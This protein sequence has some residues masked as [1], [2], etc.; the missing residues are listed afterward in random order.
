MGNADKNEMLLVLDD[1]GNS[2]DKVLN[3][4]YIHENGIFHNEVACVVVNSK[5]EILLQKRSKNKKSYPGCWALCAGHVVGYESIKHAILTEMNEELVMEIKEKN[6]FQLI[7]RMKN[8]RDDNRCFA[9][10]FCA[11]INKNAEE[12]LIQKE[13]VEE[14]KWFSLKEF[15]GMIAKEEGT[16]FKNNDYYKAI[17]EAL[18]KIFYTAGM[19]KIYATYI[20]QIEE[21][22]EA[23]KPTGRAVTREFAH[24]FGIWH[25]AASLIIINRDNRI[26]LQKR[27][28][29]KIRNAGLWDI[30]VSGHVIYGEADVNTII[31]E[32]K[33][34]TNID[35]SRDD[36]EFLRSY[37]ESVSF[38][39]MFN[40]NM[41]FNVY[42]AR[43]DLDV[44]KIKAEDFEVEELRFF[45]LDELDQMMCSYDELVYR[46]EAYKAL[47]AYMEKDG[48]S[49][50]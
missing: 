47:I 26:L 23:G 19:N 3:R 31:R 22:D 17:V 25:K 27:G 30:S 36:M 45:G 12:F 16:I 42:V 9:T 1:A 39:K 29:N 5:Q 21:L 49:L 8:E 38:N 32:A 34:E 50:C 18:D 4:K 6:I 33:E 43:M 20:E 14:I 46:P 11:I 2:T 10:C 37:K 28:K 7:P 15:K 41:I 48:L 13:E 35:I 24:N 40:D 44:A